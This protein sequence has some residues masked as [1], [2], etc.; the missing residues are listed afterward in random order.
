MGLIIEKRCVVKVLD[1]SVRIVRARPHHR[2][3]CRCFKLLSGWCA[4]WHGH[5]F[6]LP[7]SHR[8]AAGSIGKLFGCETTA[9]VAESGGLCLALVCL[10]GGADPRSWWRHKSR[11]KAVLRTSSGFRGC[12]I[13]SG[14]RGRQGVGKVAQS[15]LASLTPASPSSS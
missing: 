4:H 8:W 7:R 14:S 2:R 5:L 10:R 9:C 1:L 15:W 3:R 6:G 13:S 11:K 12:R